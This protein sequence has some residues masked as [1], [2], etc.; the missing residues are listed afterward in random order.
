MAS[1]LDWD[2]DNQIYPI[3]R[4]LVLHR[5]AKIV[6]TVHHSLKTVFTLPPKFET[7]YVP[8]HI[9][10]CGKLNAT[11]LADLVSEF[12]HDFTQPNVMPLPKILSTIST[13]TSKQSDNHFFATVVGSKEKISLYHEV[14][15]W[16]LKRDLLITL[17]LHIRVVATADLKLRVRMLRG[18]K[19]SNRPT[20]GSSGLTHGQ[21]W[22]T[23]Y[24]DRT[25]N[26]LESPD[27]N[28]D[29]MGDATWLSLSPKTARRQSR[30]LPSTESGHSITSEIDLD[31]DFE[32]GDDVELDEQDSDDVGWGG[33]EDTLWPSMISDPGRA[34]PLQRKWLSAMSED[35]DEYIASRFEQ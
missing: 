10:H 24:H 26:N 21:T 15:V 29:P 22:S 8:P 2:L 11:R 28:L 31:E 35:K 33:K 1:L 3:V 32:Y 9:S 19:K 23:S 16:M 30:Q 12:N 6:D 34:T 4:W 5:R 13:S 7:P 14:V 18:A 27:S 20:N 17:H 25:S